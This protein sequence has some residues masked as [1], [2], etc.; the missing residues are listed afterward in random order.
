MKKIAKILY[1]H[2]RNKKVRIA[3]SADVSLDTC[4]SDYVKVL[5]E[6]KLGSCHVDAYTYIGEKS[7]FTRT[8]LGPFCSVG[9]EVVC[10]LGTHPTDFVSTYPGFYSEAASGS[11]F[12]GTTYEYAHR[13][14]LGV[15]IGADVWIGARAIIMGGINIGHGAIIGA[16]AVVTKDVT[17]Y[18]IV[19]G[20]PAKLIRY[21][22]EPELINK[23]IESEWWLLPENRLKELS[24]YINDPYL[25]LD[26]I[27]KSN[28]AYRYE[29]Q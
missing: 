19:G 1:H 20:V 8:V 25:F 26:N 2:I 3:S 23:L 6:A 17:P 13:D 29:V 24:E 4:L 9:P 7:N 12:F 5:P 16:G 27:S 22:F 28:S 15:R 10:G 18:A 14:K 11:R 21:R